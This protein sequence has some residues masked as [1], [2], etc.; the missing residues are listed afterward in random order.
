MID[1]ARPC[2]GCR[3]ATGAGTVEPAR[4]PFA[5]V[6]A[7]GQPG[8]PGALQPELEALAAAVQALMPGWTVRGATLACRRSLSALA[9]VQ[10]IY[11]QF[12]ADGWFVRSET[13]R[14]LAEAGVD[15]ARMVA[16]LGLDPE[17]PAI[18]ARVAR[19][20]AQAARIDP[21]R[22]TLVVVGHGSKGS[23]ASANSTRAFAEALPDGAGFAHVTAAFIEEAPFLSD[24]VPKGPAVCLP[25]F[26]TNGGHTT[27]DIPQGWH[28]HGPIAPPIGTTGD[29]PRL[30]AAA[31][32]KAAAE[33][34]VVEG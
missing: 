16:P 26:A 2:E 4:P 3:C 12:M 14:R 30:I 10:L 13:P 11:P 17:M 6:V 33:A 21:S 25:F 8:D 24:V 9:G 15:G 23:R 18:G 22:A 28:G 19:D 29:I 31:L 20:A 5:A 32:R 1:L 34:P 7:H 27:E